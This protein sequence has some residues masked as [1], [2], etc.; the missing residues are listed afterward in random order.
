MKT[1]FLHSIT[2]CLALAFSGLHTAKADNI[3]IESGDWKLTYVEADKAFRINHKKTDG[4][5]RPVIINSIPEAT[6]NKLG[7]NTNSVTTASFSQMS[8][9]SVEIEDAFGKGIDHRFTFSGNSQ[10]QELVM[11]QSF[12]L[13]SEHEYIISVLSLIHPDSLESNYLAPICTGSTAYT[14]YVSNSNNRMLKVPFD[15][16]GFG[17]Y[18]RH[19]IDGEITSYEVSAIYEGE[20]RVGLI[21]GSVDHDLWKS[22]INIKGANNGKINALK[23][24]SG[25]SN[26]ETRDLIPHGKVV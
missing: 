4:S 6:Y 17:R 15:N 18:G 21:L 12:R 24:F 26:S 19:R 5:F 9:Q 8:Y 22:A 1:T 20:S 2:L 16:D 23:A 11:Q 7:S 25:V 13:Y 3:V 14:M 10:D